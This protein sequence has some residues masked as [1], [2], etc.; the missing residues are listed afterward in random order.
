M[1]C[2]TATLS[3]RYAPIARYRVLSVSTWP[4]RILRDGTVTPFCWLNALQFHHK[5]TKMRWAV[6]KWTMLAHTT[7]SMSNLAVWTWHCI[8]QSARCSPV[9]MQNAE[10]NICEPGNRKVATISPSLLA[11]I[12]GGISHWAAKPANKLRNFPG[13]PTPTYKAK[14]WTQICQKMAKI[15]GKQGKIT[16]LFIFLP[17]MWG[18][19]FQNDSP[20]TVEAVVRADIDGALQ[21]SQA[22]RESTAALSESMQQLA[23]KVAMQSAST[24][25]VLR[26]CKFCLL[27][28]MCC[29]VFL[30]VFFRP[31]CSSLLWTSPVF[32]SSVLV[33]AAD[34]FVVVVFILLLHHVFHLLL[35]LLLS[36]FTKELDCCKCFWEPKLEAEPCFWPLKWAGQCSGKP[37]VP[38]RTVRTVNRDHMPLNLL[39]AIGSCQTR[40]NTNTK[41]FRS[42]FPVDLDPDAPHQWGRKRKHI[43][44]WTSTGFWRGRP[45]HEGFQKT[46][47]RFG[48]IF[49]S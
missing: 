16:S 26:A 41:S 19:V 48:A 4:N 31:S 42:G 39:Q 25:E 9:L 8:Q 43:E 7:E 32:S 46:L 21:H 10:L 1:L 27:V 12:S 22:A 35:L 2:A 5:L 33:V 47:Y 3:Q 28:L 37:I 17:C 11:A 30:Y 14:I 18:S 36:S 40:N 24:Q 20:Q 13:T 29:F 44:A 49:G 15:A 45:W 6:A 34:V 38:K 23:D